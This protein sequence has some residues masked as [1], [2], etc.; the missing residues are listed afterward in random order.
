VAKQDLSFEA[1]L[2][3]LEKIVAKLES[4]ELTLSGA[5]EQFEK[6]VA[7]MKVCDSHLKSAEGKIRELL[8]GTDGEFI[9][10]VLGVSGG[11]DGGATSDD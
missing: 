6:G 4:P 10:S 2:K 5:L 8:A 11:E 3:E 9:E 7:L 1:A